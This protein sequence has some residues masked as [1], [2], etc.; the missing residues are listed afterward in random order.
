V[1]LELVSKDRSK[2]LP[3][4]YVS[5]QMLIWLLRFIFASIM[6]KIISNGHS[7][8]TSLTSIPMDVYCNI[9]PIQISSFFWGNPNQKLKSMGRNKIKMSEVDLRETKKRR[10]KSNIPHVIDE[11]ISD[12][13]DKIIE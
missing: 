7:T 8:A 11:K 9:F 5:E 1:I 4:I 10:L 12:K 13:I 6:P 2:L 3:E